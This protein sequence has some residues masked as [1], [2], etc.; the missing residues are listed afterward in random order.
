[1]VDAVSPVYE[2]HFTRTPLNL[3]GGHGWKRLMAFRVDQY[4]ITLGGMPLQ[5]R[6]QTAVVPWAEIEAVV[7]WGQKTAQL[8]PI[9]CVG[10]KCRPG[11]AA[12]PGPNQNLKP[13]TAAR[14]APHIEY[15]VV[16]DSRTMVLWHIDPD[17]L[18]T[19]LRAFAP[20]VPL[21][22]HQQYWKG[23]SGGIDLDVLP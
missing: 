14:V 19:A 18:T 6:R 11:S 15:E 21:R 2:E 16:R 5:Y 23:R 9:R 7:L 12:L 3:L 8:R 13:E 17:R 4:G 20:G 10:V 1:M 22:F